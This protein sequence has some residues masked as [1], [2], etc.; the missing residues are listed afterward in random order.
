MPST[1][2]TQE[3]SIDATHKVDVTSTTGFPSSGEIKVDNEIIAYTST[4]GT[5]FGSG[6]TN[7]LVRGVRTVRVQHP[8]GAT[9]TVAGRRFE[10]DFFTVFQD[11]RPIS[12]ADACAYLITTTG[13]PFSQQLWLTTQAPAVVV[14]PETHGHSYVLSGNYTGGDFTLYFWDRHKNMIGT[15]QRYR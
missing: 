8:E 6:S 1:K 15:E 13:V 9:V 12:V 3:L 2:T 7:A 10:A 11:D 5:Q 14:F 4:T